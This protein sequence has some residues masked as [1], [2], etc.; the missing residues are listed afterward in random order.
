MRLPLG[1]TIRAGTTGDAP[2]IQRVH[3]ESIRGVGEGVYSRAETESWATGLD[4]RGYVSGMTHGGESFLVAEASRKGVVGFCSH[5]GDRVYGLY[6]LPEWARRGIGSALLGMAEAAIVASG[7]VR[8]R[9]SASLSG[10]RFYEGRGYR[11]VGRL[12]WKTRGGL[13]IEALE[14]ERQTKRL[15]PTPA[16][17][18]RGRR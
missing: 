1:V 13:V 4:P 17:R 3:Q 10:R 14:M 11:V 8:I 9:L 15:A 6:I 5:S 12:D 16:T 18:G 7:H 2:F